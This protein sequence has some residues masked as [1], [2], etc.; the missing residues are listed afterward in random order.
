MY[1]CPPT[2]FRVSNIV[3][4]FIDT[5]R[6]SEPNFVDAMVSRISRDDRRFACFAVL[7]LS[8]LFGC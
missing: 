1:A 6:R 4:K 5:S 2:R 3:A 8:W 7:R